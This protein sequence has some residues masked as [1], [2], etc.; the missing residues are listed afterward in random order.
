MGAC[1]SSTLVLLI[2]PLNSEPHVASSQLDKVQSSSILSQE[3]GRGSS[4]NLRGAGGGRWEVGAQIGLGKKLS[5]KVMFPLRKIVHL[6]VRDSCL[7]H[8]KLSL[9]SSFC[10]L[11]SAGGQYIGRTRDA[12]FHTRPTGVRADRQQHLCSLRG[13]PGYPPSRIL[14]C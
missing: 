6:F 13:Y 12:G 11:V 7:I 1:E 9:K 4:T 8:E 2:Q 5:C 10:N 3:Q 14:K